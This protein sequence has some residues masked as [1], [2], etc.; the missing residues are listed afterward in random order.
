MGLPAGDHL[1]RLRAAVL[2]AVLVVDHLLDLE[3]ATELHLLH[4]AGLSTDGARVNGLPQF[5]WSTIF[6]PGGEALLSR[7][8][9]LLRAVVW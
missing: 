8:F 7:H 6:V 5:S 9:I 3:L 4:L 2:E 1:Q